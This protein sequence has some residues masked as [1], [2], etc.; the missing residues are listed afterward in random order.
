VMNWIEVNVVFDFPDR[1][2]AVDLISD[3]FYDLDLKGVVVEEPGIEDS[4]DWGRDAV[5]PENDAVIGYLPCDD[6]LEGKCKTIEEGLARLEEKTGIRY[7]IFYA[8]VDETNWTESWKAYFHPEK[9]TDRIVVKPSWRTYSRNDQEIVIEIDPGMAFG[10][11]THPTTRMC[12]ILLDKYLKKDDRFLDVGT[13]SGILLVAAAKLGAGAV[14]GTDNDPV[15]IDVAC[16]NLIQNKIPESTFKVVSVDLIDQISEKFDLVA[17][18][19]TTK[20]VLI[21]LDVIKRV[22]APDGIFI[23][24]GIIEPEKSMILE[25]MDHLNFDVVD[26]RLKDEWIAIAGRSKRQKN[27]A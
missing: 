10:T 14:W 11:G 4:E 9:I 16:N 20:T 5:V 6:T 12:M 8:Q 15:A 17:A 18:N 7:R 27:E 2:L 26:V 19:L 22:L 23:C 3:L 24:S 13:G 1:Q 21:L 25:K